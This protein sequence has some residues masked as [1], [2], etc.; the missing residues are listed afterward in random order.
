MTPLHR[1]LDSLV[2]RYNVPGF[3]DADPI[4]FPKRYTDKRDIEISAFL[5]STIS[6]GRRAMILANAEKIDTILCRKPHRFILEGDIENI[7][8][9]NI[10]RTFFGKHLR[11]ALRGLREIYSRYGSME[12]LA[13]ACGA[14]NAGAPAWELAN[15]INGIFADANAAAPLEGPSRC[16]PDKPEKSALKRFNM[17]LRWLV[18]NDG[19]VDIGCW[20]VLKPSQLYIP[21]D[22][23]SANTSRMLKLLGRSGNDRKA[24]EELTHALRAFRPDDPVIYD[25]ALF[26]AGEEGIELVK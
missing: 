9:A 10:H 5:T 11:Y 1:Y 25:F 8:D 2:E 22:V 19:I 15:A 7:S 4:Q 23:H 13:V 16:L 18:R 6:W 24:V 20:E 17:A 26:G 3:A 14:V 21:L 12:D